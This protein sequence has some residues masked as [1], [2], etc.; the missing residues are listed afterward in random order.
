MQKP[1]LGLLEK[2]NLPEQWQNVVHVFSRLIL[3]S[4]SSVSTI[5]WC[6]LFSGMGTG[7]VGEVEVEPGS[8]DAKRLYRAH[9][10]EAAAA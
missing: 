1:K 4:S 3:V 5:R 6:L 8:S 10:E 7:G 2:H 9:S